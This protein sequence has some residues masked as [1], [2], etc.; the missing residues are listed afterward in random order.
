MSTASPVDDKGGESVGKPR[1]RSK[2][3]RASRKR[4][5]AAK[6]FLFVEARTLRGLGVALAVAAFVLFYYHVGRAWLG[7]HHIRTFMDED[8]ATA[9]KAVLALSAIALSGWA[10]LQRLK[11]RPFPKSTITAV[12]VAYGAL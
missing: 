1:S 2:G 6:T 10:L 9:T 3:A 12:M 4:P 11:G 8:V 5:R 7:Q